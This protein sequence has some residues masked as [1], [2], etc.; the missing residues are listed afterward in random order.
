ML[1]Q[2]ARTRAWARDRKGRSVGVTPRRAPLTRD[3]HHFYSIDVTPTQEVAPEPGPRP[4][5]LV[6]EVDARTLITLF[7]GLVVAALVVGLVEAAGDMLVRIATG[8]LLALALDPVVCSVR[9]RLRCRRWVAVVGVIGL[10]LGALATLIVVMGP[11]ALEQAERFGNELPDTVRG[12][13]DL[14]LVGERLRD[15]DAATSVEQWVADLPERVDSETLTNVVRALIDGA[16]TMSVIVLVAFAVLLDG[17]LIVQRVRAVVP[18][19]RRERA[20]AIGRVFYQVLAR[21]FAGSLFVAFLA[22]LYVLAVGLALGVPLTPLAALWV[23]LT[24]LIPQIGGFLGGSVFTV[25]GFAAGPAVG[26]AV[27]VLF[28]LYLNI[29]NHLLQPAIVGDAV[30][31]SP[32]VTMLAALVGGAAAGIPGALVATPLAGT[33]KALY[34]QARHGRVPERR[35]ETIAGRVGRLLRGAA[36]RP[37]P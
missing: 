23:V 14:P 37:H 32:P 35:H 29:E 6:V 13:Y 16:S 15:A 12:L 31:L 26:V 4:R 17:E 22:G 10:V 27:L 3:V 28:V 20:D 25:L 5:R 11:S 36:R 19:A 30:D 18:E 9:D 8:V 24:N 2:R 1:D 33:V 7:G 21:Y 34:L